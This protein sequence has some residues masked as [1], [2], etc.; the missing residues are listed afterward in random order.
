MVESPRRADLRLTISAYSPYREL[1]GELADKFA[2]YAGLSVERRADVV[3]AVLRTVDESGDDREIE[4]DLTA[5]G[6]TVIVTAVPT[7]AERPAR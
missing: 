4:I 3:A 1:A 5:E 7:S 6:G 2:E